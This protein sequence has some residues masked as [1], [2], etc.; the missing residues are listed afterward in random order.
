MAFLIL[1]RSRGIVIAVKPPWERAV[2]GVV[3]QA[4]A[5]LKRD[6]ALAPISAFSLIGAAIC[7]GAAYFVPAYGHDF[8]Y[9][10][11]A[12]LTPPPIAYFIFLFRD[13]NRL[14]SEKYQ[15]TQARLQQV[16]LGKELSKP[17]AES[18]L[19][20]PVSNPALPPPEPLTEGEQ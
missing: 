7:F 16:V 17:L 19:P 3:N 14:Q 13:P 9:A 12:L 11:L 20:P 2:L 15:L 4:G 8:V 1:E 6:N 10:G 18:D 5:I